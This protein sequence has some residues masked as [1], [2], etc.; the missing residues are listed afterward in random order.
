MLP[1][2]SRGAE[3]LHTPLKYL[4]WNYLDPLEIRLLTIDLILNIAMEH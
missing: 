4:K 2:L 3:H 1:L